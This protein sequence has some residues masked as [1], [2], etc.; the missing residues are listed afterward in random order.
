MKKTLLIIAGMS[1]FVLSVYGQNTSVTNNNTITINGDVYY[2]RPSTTR[3]SPL[4]RSTPA[5]GFIGEGHWYGA[6][7]ARAWASIAD[8]AVERCRLSTFP[9]RPGNSQVV[10]IHQVH[11]NPNRSFNPR[12]PLS[13]YNSLGYIEI[14][15]WVVR[16]NEKMENGHR[17][18]RTF[19]F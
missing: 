7:A 15:Y 6:D 16:R 10:Y 4:P 8:W 1:I 19:Y 9:I 14:F 3:S 12:L 18:I 13:E 17:Q 5:S 11:A 2:F